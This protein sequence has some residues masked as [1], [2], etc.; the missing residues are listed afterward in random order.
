MQHRGQH[1]AHQQGGGR[2]DPGRS[3]LAGPG[4]QLGQRELAAGIEGRD[5][6][7]ARERHRRPPSRG[8]PGHGARER[9]LDLGVPQAEPVPTVQDRAVHRLALEE[10][11]VG[12]AEVDHLRLVGHEELGVAARD[13]GIGE[14]ELAAAAPPDVCRARTE[15]D[16]PAGVGAG[17]DGRLG[18]SAAPVGIA[19]AAPGHRDMDTRAEPALGES[20]PRVDGAEV[21]VD[22][23]ERELALRL[24]DR[25]AGAG[26]VGEREVLREL[27]DGRGG[28]DGRH[29]VGVDLSGGAEGEL[30]FH[31]VVALL[32]GRRRRGVGCRWAGA[33]LRA[34]SGRTSRSARSRCQLPASVRR[35]ERAALASCQ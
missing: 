15:R 3:L 14:L 13:L 33:V 1:H 19:V 26:G 30:Q 32:V 12:G 9:E 25:C 6:G 11:P 8:E 16:L 18:D 27:A 28:V 23:G 4:G 31:E 22:E 7:R 34:R 35:S 17:D 2:G 20:G 29:E 10:D 24:G 5:A 21:L